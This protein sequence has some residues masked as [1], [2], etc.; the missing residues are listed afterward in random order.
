M[1]MAMTGDAQLP[2]PSPR[3]KRTI[4]VKRKAVKRTVRHFRPDG[5][6]HDVVTLLT[7]PAV[8]AA[9][10]HKLVCLC[11]S[12][13]VLA[14]WAMVL[15]L[16]CCGQPPPAAQTA[17]SQGHEGRRRSRKKRKRNSSDKKPTRS[18]FFVPVCFAA[19]EHCL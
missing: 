1:S 11:R 8:V 6:V 7:D 10:T 3:G 4:K 13:A 18:A 9:Y 17:G 2:R 12:L 16:C 19:D 14:R 5:T 15:T